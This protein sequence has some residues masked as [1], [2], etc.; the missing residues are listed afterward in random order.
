MEYCPAKQLIFHKN[1]SSGSTNW[2]ARST[3]RDGSIDWAYLNTNAGWSNASGDYTNAWTSTKFSIG[4]DNVTNTS[5]DDY[6]AYCFSEV[7]GYSAIG[8]YLG[9][10]HTDGAFIHT[11]FRPAFLLIKKHNSTDSWNL[12]DTTRDPHNLTFHRVFCPESD[13]EST[14]TSDTTSKCDIYSNGFKWRGTSNDTNGSGDNYIYY[15]IAD[16]PFKYANPR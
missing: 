11:G 4:T 7:Y 9:T 12:W 2:L 15:A 10:G 5:G 1:L 13:A 8:N 3:A 6:I 16:Q 14:G